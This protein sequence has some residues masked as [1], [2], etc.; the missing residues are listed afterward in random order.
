MSFHGYWMM[1][2]LDLVSVLQ[3][4]SVVRAPSVVYVLLSV[5]LPA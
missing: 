2:V 1:F 4:I 5:I 3:D